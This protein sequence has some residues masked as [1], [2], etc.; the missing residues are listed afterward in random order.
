MNLSTRTLLGMPVLRIEGDVDPDDAPVLEL[1]A[2]EALGLHGTRVILDMEGCTY[3]SS[4]GLAVLLSLTRWARS[5]EGLIV[6]VQPNA[7]ILRLLQLVRLT[8]ERG[9]RVTVDLE[10]AAQ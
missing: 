3:V 6:A 5:K 10:S 8:E 1:A 9:F 7:Q 2:W 4:A